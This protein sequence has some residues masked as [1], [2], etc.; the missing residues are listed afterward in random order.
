MKTK[1]TGICV[2]FT[3]CC[4]KKTITLQFFCA[5]NLNILPPVTL[6]SVDVSLLMHMIKQLQIEVNLL[7][8]ASVAQRDLTDGIHK[9]MR[10]LDE[11]VTMI[12]T[13]NVVPEGNTS[14]VVPVVDATPPATGGTTTRR[15]MLRLLLPEEC[16]RTLVL[17]RSMRLLLYQGGL[18]RV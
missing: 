16:L 2:I 3:T 12:E 18:I 17:P 8:A 11:R 5:K 15:Q 13:P 6:K 14:P 10:S 7:S 1:V 4:K 9:I